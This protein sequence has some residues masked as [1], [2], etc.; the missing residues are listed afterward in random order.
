MLKVLW[1]TSF[2]PPALLNPAGPSNLSTHLSP[3]DLPTCH[4]LESPLSGPHTSAVHLYFLPPPA[5]TGDAQRE[6]DSRAPVLACALQMRAACPWARM[7]EIAAVRL[8][9]KP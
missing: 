9:N 1:S 3:A 4:F 7:P 5:R 6:G 8:H 2:F